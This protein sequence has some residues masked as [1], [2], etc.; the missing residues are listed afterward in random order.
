MWEG[1]GGREEVGDVRGEVGVRRKRWGK[2]GTKAE[3]EGK[4]K[5][6]SMGRRRR[7]KKRGESK[8]NLL[9]SVA[10]PQALD[11]SPALCLSSFS[12]SSRECV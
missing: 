7:K 5:G 6:G 10:V 4:E 11:S 1:G 8:E 12:S 3:E 9:F 2:C